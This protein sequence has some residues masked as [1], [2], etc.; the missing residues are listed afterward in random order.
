MSFVPTFRT[1]TTR[2]LPSAKNTVTGVILPMF[3]WDEGKHQIGSPQW[4]VSHVPY[5]SADSRD[6]KGHPTVIVPCAFVY[7]HGRVGPKEDDY[8]S[9]I[10]RRDFLMRHEGDSIED[11]LVDIHTLAKKEE[12]RWHYLTKPKTA[13]DGKDAAIKWPST[14]CMFNFFGVS[15]KEQGQPAK[16]G[17][18]QSS[19]MA[20]VEFTRLMNITRMPGQVPVPRDSDWPDYLYGDVTNPNRPLQV[21]TIQR[22]AEGNDMTKYT[23][24]MFSSNEVSLMGAVAAPVI[25]QSILA[26]R[27]NLWDS[28]TYNI[29]GYQEF[30]D[31]IVS[32]GWYDLELVREACGNKGNIG[33]VQHTGQPQPGYQ[34]TAQ[35]AYQPPPTTAYPQQ[36]PA[37]PATVQY[38]AP[39]AVTDAIP[40][41]HK[42]WVS[43]PAGVVEMTADQL[44]AAVIGSG[45]ASM[46]VMAG[47]QVGGWR[48]AAD[49]GFTPP[50]PVYQAPPPPPAP[51]VYQAPPL[52]PPPPAPPVYQ[53][54][55]QPAAPPMY[56]PA[57]PIQQ[58]PQQADWGPDGRGTRTPPQQPVYPAVTP[59]AYRDPAADDAPWATAPAP[60]PEAGQPDPGLS[61][62][63]FYA[64]YQGRSARELNEEVDRLTSLLTSGKLDSDGIARLTT[65]GALA[66]AA[67][68]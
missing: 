47:S 39:A 25:P 21:T 19:K 42:Y 26:Q 68:Q 29:L 43:G 24:W 31:R 64:E 6:E 63:P 35:P 50:A 12:S 30:L 46:P 4:A 57:A 44:R 62:M 27:I 8:V 23:G 55:A 56:Q 15:T 38:S 52:P 16:L 18:L 22:T 65:V 2:F 48:T 14:R 28:A 7:I 59:P 5:R 9:A 67:A 33:G 1:P 51:P 66:G 11:P 20:H 37:Q 40:M 53:A 34:P 49:F 3:D 10:S 41:D 13:K 60:Q 32:E 36:Y 61:A 17:A 45:N 54:P 58:P